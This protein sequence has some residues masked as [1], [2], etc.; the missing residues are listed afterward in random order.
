[1]SSNPVHTYLVIDN[2]L[3]SSWAGAQQK[4]GKQILGS[5]ALRVNQED[6][7]SL[8]FDESRIATARNF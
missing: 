6:F 1:M 7:A 5:E 3:S 4:L 2:K 8:I